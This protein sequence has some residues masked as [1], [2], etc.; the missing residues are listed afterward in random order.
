MDTIDYT[1]GVPTEP[2][3]GFMEWFERKC[4]DLDEYIV[5]R[6]ASVYDPLEDR[7]VKSV[8]CRCTACDTEFFMPYKKAEECHIGHAPA[9]FGFY[10]RATDEYVI[11]GNKTSCPYCDKEVKCVHIG[12][13]GSKDK[14]TLQESYPAS[15]GV[16]N[17]RLTVMCW[18][19]CRE[20]YKDGHIAF[21]SHPFEAYIAEERK[22]IKLC[23]YYRSYWGSCVQLDVWERRSRYDDTF[24]RIESEYIFPFDSNMIIGTSAEN[25]KLDVYIN[26]NVEVRP[27]SYLYLWI[28]KHNIE[29][30]VM[31]GGARLLNE[32]IEDNS[33]RNSSI[34]RIKC[35][36]NKKAKPHEMLGLTK[37]EYKY[38]IAHKW[39]PDMLNIYV[40][41]KKYGMKPKE[42]R[43]VYELIGLFS[44]NDL[45]ENNLYGQTNIMKT[46]RYLKK[47]HTKYPNEYNGVSALLDYL[48]MAEQEGC[49]LT[50]EDV[51]YPAN[52]A[53]AHDRLS[54]QIKVRKNKETDKKFIKRFNQ[55]SKYRYSAHGL[56]IHPARSQNEMVYEGE[57]LHH[58]VGSYVSS[59][60][61]GKTAIFFIRHIDQ[62]EKPYF[63]LEL[64]EKSLKVKQNRGLRNCGRTDEVK[65]FEA[66]W[67][68]FIKS[69]TEKGEKDQWKTA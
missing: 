21:E 6:A 4:T 18:R 46:C 25:C 33:G 54:A 65:E 20:L 11:Q 2:P 52:L 40:K 63:T 44:F 5:Y 14:R 22:I 10:N 3:P 60:A 13:F 8:Q 19:I 64:D 55:L 32:I 36:N 9:P 26:K 7:R 48:R 51:K 66:E 37:P 15:V 43:G 41:S 56:E 29:N 68:E 53:V 58:C 57:R 59:H 35:I 67:L 24:G 38:A 12:N 39:K 16:Y 49:D 47:Q 34:A 1:I 69:V 50:L 28:K 31:S 30:I 45:F 17:N 61:D 42:V 27:I 23:G 62:P